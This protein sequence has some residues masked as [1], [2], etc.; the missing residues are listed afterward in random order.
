MAVIWIWGLYVPNCTHNL[1]SVGKLNELCFNFNIGQNAF[2]LYK[3][4]YY[5]G[6]S[7][8]FNG[9]CHFNLDENFIES[10]FNVTHNFCL[11]RS[12]HNEHFHFL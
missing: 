12:A 3:E 6:S 1:V 10:L 8:M 11:K 7:A 2:S 9:L 4:N 5:Y